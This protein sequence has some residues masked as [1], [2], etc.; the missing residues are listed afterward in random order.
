MDDIRLIQD[1]VFLRGKTEV[2][3][4]GDVGIDVFYQ[5]DEEVTLQPLERG[6]FGTGVDAIFLKD[7]YFIQVC[8]RSGLAFKHGI[9]VLNAPGI[10]DSGFTG[11]I[12][13]CL[14]NLSNEEYTIKPGAK[15]AQLVVAKDYN[16]SS[17]EGSVR[18][19]SGF[20]SSGF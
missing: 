16:M 6:T 11:E 17:E 5:G 10:V 13:V 18:G 4:A 12:A 9:T 15:I 19:D 2:A 1:I 7:G 3:H 8:P 14:V 20:G